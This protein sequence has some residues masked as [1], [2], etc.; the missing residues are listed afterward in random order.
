MT[1]ISS[2][3]NVIG[4]WP[5]RKVLADEIETTVGRVNKWAQ[6]GSIPARFHARLL[7]S[8]V[9]RGIHLTAEDLTRLHDIVGEE[10]A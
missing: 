4:L 5:S 2:I 7:R 6:T 1:E 3:K 8:A 10:A 9:A